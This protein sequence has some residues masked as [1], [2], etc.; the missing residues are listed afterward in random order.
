MPAGRPE[1][2]IT[3]SCT[4]E[5]EPSDSLTVLPVQIA[6]TPMTPSAHTPTSR[7]D[8]HTVAPVPTDT[9]VDKGQPQA[10]TDSCEESVPVPGT[11]TPAPPTNPSLAEDSPQL[12]NGPAP[13]KRKV[14]A[15]AIISESISNK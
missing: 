3:Q 11:V 7:P 5:S 6:Q 13:K 10:T 1:Q 4:S 15:P 14:D 12:A 2:I 9:N 8:S